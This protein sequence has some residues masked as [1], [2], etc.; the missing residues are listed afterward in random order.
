MPIIVFDIIHGSRIQN[1]FMHA[2]DVYEKGKQ[3]G[4]YEPYRLKYAGAPTDDNLI[5]LQKLLKDAFEAVGQH[6][7]FLSI[8]HD[9]IKYINHIPPYIK[10]DV[11]TI[12]TGHHWILFRDMLTSLGYE[13][14]TT[15]YMQVLTA[16]HKL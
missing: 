2:G 5:S 14:T 4:N 6:I 15:E 7:I 11:Q 1:D 8:I 13:V 9:G 3:L 16:K 10:P 12:S